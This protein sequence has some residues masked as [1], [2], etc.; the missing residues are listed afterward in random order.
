VSSA[1]TAA[2]GVSA[3]SPASGATSGDDA[4]SAPRHIAERY[5]LQTRLG[6]GGM[7]EVYAAIDTRTGA[8]IAL[9]LVRRDGASSLRVERLLREAQ[10]AARIP[11]PGIVRILDVGEDPIADVAFIAQELVRGETLRARMDRGGRLPE[12]LAVAIAT[13]LAE[14][15]AASHD[16]GVVHRDLKPENV[17]LEDVDGVP[18][19]RLIDF[20]VARFLARDDVAKLTSTGASLG[21][22]AYMSPEQA[23]GEDGVDE[24]TDIWALGV[25]LYEML[26]GW[27][28]FSR[29]SAHATLAAVLLD[30]VPPVGARAP[31]VSAR[32]AL[33]VHRAL[34]RNRVER[35]G[36]MREF[37]A[38]L[39]AAAGDAATR[40]SAERPLPRSTRAF[41][42]GGAVL[43]VL[44]ALSSRWLSGPS[45]STTSPRLA[46][47]PSP[48][49]VSPSSTPPREAAPVA[50]PTVATSERPSSPPPMRAPAVR[51]GRVHARPSG[52]E[53]ATHRRT[54][55]APIVGL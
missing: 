8:R 48:V 53:A 18:R 34:H 49:L 15:L 32:V 30:A 3:G 40:V 36:T 7:G 26:T 16:A 45:A 39:G 21:T 23:R 17:I 54:N 43:V 51:R 37:S 35:W 42:I 12:R 10:A 1:A 46:P 29:A 55:G 11:H 27:A 4:H 47:T 22:P 9:K 14:V 24:Q 33:V 31:E 52:L 50:A 28:P 38:A 6:E 5:A 44:A 2:V 19:P 13:C 41:V 20:G 25:V